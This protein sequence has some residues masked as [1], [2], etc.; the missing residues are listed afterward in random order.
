MKKTIKKHPN[1]MGDIVASS[2]ASDQYSLS[3]KFNKVIKKVST[4]YQDSITSPLTVTL[5]DEPRTNAY[6]IWDS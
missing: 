3:R 5:G 6:V 2:S 1:L 4:Q